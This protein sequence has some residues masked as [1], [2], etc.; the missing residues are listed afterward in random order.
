MVRKGKGRMQPG[1]RESHAKNIH[2]QGTENDEKV[3]NEQRMI[4]EETGG[5]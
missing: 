1:T 4:E 5:G 2:M 3:Y